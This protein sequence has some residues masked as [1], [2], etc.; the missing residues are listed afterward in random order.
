MA[1]FTTTAANAVVDVKLEFPAPIPAPSPTY[2]V[3]IYGDS[4]GTPSTTSLYVDAADRTPPVGGGPVTI[5]LPAPVAVAAGNFYV[6]VQQ[7]LAVNAGLGF[8]NEQPLR[9]GAFYLAAPLPVASWSDEQTQAG[10]GFK[11]NVGVNLRNGVPTPTSAV[12]RKTHGAAGDFDIDLLGANPIEC[13]T[14]GAGNDY[15]IVYTFPSAV[16]F[17][18]ASLSAGTGSVM[19][20]SGS[21]TTTVT[22]NLT[23]V[24]NIQRITVKLTALTEVATPANTGDLGVTMGVLVGDTNNNGAVN[25]GDT[26]QTKGRSGQTTD[27]TNFRSDVNTDGI[28]NAGDSSAVKSRSGTALP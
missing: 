25:A 5:T 8:D 18:S 26:A 14:G 1:K 15:K 6:G 19:S 7:T 17:S 12:S 4:G 11:L 24:T 27:G 20:S 22:V 9:S 28:I 10:A 13:R 21:G 23:G 2:R 3:A 16:T